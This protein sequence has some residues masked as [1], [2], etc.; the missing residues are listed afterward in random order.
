MAP[1]GGSIFSAITIGK[2]IP[3]NPKITPL[4][5]PAEQNGDVAA[6]ADGQ[7]PE[8]QTTTLKEGASPGPI[9][10][11]NVVSPLDAAQNGS[12]ATALVPELGKVGPAYVIDVDFSAAGGPTLSSGEQ[13]EPLNPIPKGTLEESV[14]APK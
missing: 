5:Q 2:P 11:I 7:R 14:A 3:E 12:P 13:S 10:G 1:V 4:A 9:P 6:E 8:V